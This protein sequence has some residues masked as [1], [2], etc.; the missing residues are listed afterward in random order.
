VSKVRL[1]YLEKVNEKLDIT[2]QAYRVVLVVS[3]VNSLRTPEHFY[4]DRR[5]LCLTPYPDRAE[6]KGSGLKKSRS[7]YSITRMRKLDQNH[8]LKDR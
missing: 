1:D 3:A 8:L 5:A 2:C 4:Q 7:C 6:E